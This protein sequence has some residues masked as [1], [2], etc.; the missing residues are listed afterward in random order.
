MNEDSFST[1]PGLGGEDAGESD[2]RIPWEVLVGLYE[3]MPNSDQEIG[4]FACAVLRVR[5]IYEAANAWQE[6]I[7]NLTMLSLRGGRRRNHT[8][9][10]PAKTPRMESEEGSSSTKIGLE[11]VIQLSHHP[12]LSTVRDRKSECVTVPCRDTSHPIFVSSTGCY[13]QRICC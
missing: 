12:I 10:S 13:A 8:A 4:D 3:R 11:K 6:E 1:K 9:A 5:E 2:T 7:S